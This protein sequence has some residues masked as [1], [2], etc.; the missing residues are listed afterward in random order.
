MTAVRDYTYRT[1]F[2]K[3]ALAALL[4]LQGA[5]ISRLLGPEGRGLFSKLQASLNFFILFLGLG[6]TSA[7]IYYFAN[8]KISPGKVLGAS[9]IV[10]ASGVIV[11]FAGLIGVHFFPA[12]DYIFPEH[13]RGFFF[14]F[15]L[16]ASFGTSQLQLLYSAMLRSRS[17]FYV[18]NRLEI[19]NAIVRLL[20]LAVL[21]P[22][23]NSVS[24]EMI[25][26]IDLGVHVL[27]T[28]WFWRASSKLIEEKSDF[29]LSWA[30]DIKPM[31]Q[32]SSLLYVSFLIN[33]VYTRVDVWIVE[34]RN[35][36]AQLGVYSVAYGLVQVLTFMPVTLNSVLF[37]HIAGSTPE[38]GMKSLSFFSRLNFSLLV[39]AGA[40][41]TVFARPLIVLLYGSDFAGAV[42]PLQILTWA[43]V[44]MSI[45]HLFS[46]YNVAQG[47]VA[48]NFVCEAVALVLGVALN[49]VLVPMW[50]IFGA[51][52]ASLFSNAVAC[53]FIVFWALRSHAVALSDFLWIR[54]TDVKT[55]VRGGVWP[56]PFEPARYI[57]RLDDACETYRREVWLKLEEVLDRYDI[58]PIVGVIPKNIDPALK[59][60][61][62]DPEF[63]DRVRNWQKKG[64]IIAMHGYRHDL[65]NS[66]KQGSLV[67]IQPLTEFAGFPA[68][69][70]REKIRLAWGIF[71][72][73]QVKPT[74][75]MAPAHSFDRITLDILREETDIRMITD[76]L[77]VLPYQEHGFT[78]LPQQS[79]SLRTRSFGVWT[80]CLHPNSMDDADLKRLEDALGHVRPYILSDY[81]KLA[82]EFKERARGFVDRVFFGWFVFR[83]RVMSFLFD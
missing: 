39:F 31:F 80:T 40:F 32:F 13:Y 82:K 75:W 10:S 52:A 26:G 51:A 63:W 54:R 60:G 78:W 76:G 55:L 44:L 70:Q 74:M 42:L 48:A 21:M 1:L 3:L 7:I 2:A 59:F 34:S 12:F 33:F 8:R 28:V 41:L 24:I 11:L 49:I 53:T 72:R 17:H 29:D 81:E 77:G 46:Y 57:L 37:P 61:A 67:P 9:L 16:L 6:V 18:H 25:F 38:E 15:Y 79:W 47:Q 68:E 71:R 56:L 30:V 43:T 83:M 58:K 23:K 4:V 36:L 50:G 20:A 35:G 5:A 65:R 64:W 45:K 22:F 73:E 69:N 62:P 66:G 14:S 27:K 19:W